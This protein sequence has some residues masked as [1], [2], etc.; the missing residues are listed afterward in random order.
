MS[1]TGRFLDQHLPHF[2]RNWGL[3]FLWGILLMLVGI[4]AVS[5]VT[6]TTLVS[7]VV[8]GF[9]IFFTG[10][11][12]LID[13]FTFWMGKSHGFV[14]HLLFAI[15]YL[16]AG[17]LLISNPVQGSITITF[18]L[19]LLYTFL[20]TVR[21]IATLSTRL[22]SWGWAFFNGLISLI[23][24]ILILMSWPDSSVFVI[25]LFIGIDLFFLGLAYTMA[26]VAAKRS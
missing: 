19:G 21:I 11:V 13:T 4:L 25:G 9:I 24:G 2:S 6:L 10:C 14:L 17:S 5:A 15:L 20:G 16:A 1:I 22:P 12:V 26:A 7:V 18:L 23:I 3:F 8:L